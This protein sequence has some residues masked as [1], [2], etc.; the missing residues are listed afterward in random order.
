MDVSDLEEA[1]GS[2]RE[3]VWCVSF[4]VGIRSDVTDDT[5]CHNENLAFAVF[6]RFEIM[7]VRV[8]GEFTPFGE[9]YLK[10]HPLLAH[11]ISKFDDIDLS[12]FSLAETK[13]WGASTP[14]QAYH[15][16]SSRDIDNDDEPNSTPLK[17]RQSS[18]RARLR[19]D[20]EQTFDEE[21]YV[22]GSTVIWSQGHILKSSYNFED[23]L[24]PVLM[25]L[26]AYFPVEETSAITSASSQYPLD[27]DID[28]SCLIRSN[29]GKTVIGKAIAAA[30]QLP[31]R[32]LQRALCVLLRSTA[33]I[34][35]PSG[36]SYTVHLP[37]IVHRAW[38]LDVGILLQR[39][40]ETEELQPSSFGLPDVPPTAVLFSLLDPFDEITM[41]SKTGQITVA[42]VQQ[43]NIYEPTNPFTDHN[44][45]V[46]FV[47]EGNRLGGTPFVVTFHR[48]QLR[49][50][51]WRYAT[52]PEE[53][54]YPK[55]KTAGRTLRR[56][57]SGLSTAP[58]AGGVL[59]SSTPSPL[60]RRNSL[61]R[62]NSDTS[63]VLD[64][65]VHNDNVQSQQ[66]TQM[67]SVTYLEQVWMETEA[68]RYEQ[69]P[70][71]LP[72]ASFVLSPLSRGTLR[73]D[74]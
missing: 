56:D 15:L 74:D 66:D 5:T 24:E 41:V 29:N 17:S 37:F 39:I 72:S 36:L 18:G 51:V 23:E 63:I 7:E 16:T 49:H 10:E 48:E 34:Y 67:K 28:R 4:F 42:G 69:T 32:K 59:A 33:K 62:T 30:S 38:A 58:I 64:R 46:L 25:A 21:L 11:S 14:K 45:E 6:V 73:G 61:T 57:P 55:E 8:F 9:Q 44:H 26:F 1:M 70:W 60:L 53:G 65:V 35:F 52:R 40:P 31:K 12:S 27:F 3:E 20:G 19:G 43:V 71:I 22:A 2:V 47:S 54:D 50:Y 68:T 13:P